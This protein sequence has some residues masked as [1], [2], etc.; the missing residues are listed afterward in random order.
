MGPT[1]ADVTGSPHRWPTST[2]MV[3]MG[4]INGPTSADVAGGPIHARPSIADVALVGPTSR[5]HT[6]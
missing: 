2:D 4:P 5:A 1:Y 6:C 3:L